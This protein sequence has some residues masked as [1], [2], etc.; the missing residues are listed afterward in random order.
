ML[1]SKKVFVDTCVVIEFLKE[2]LELNKSNCYIS[3]I[4]LMEL[5][6]GAKNKQDLREIK[7]KLQGFKLLETNQEVIDLSTQIIEHF[8]LSHN[9]KI[10]DAII[11]STC[12]IH[13]LP[14]ATYNIKDFKYIPNLE[15]VGN[16][17][18]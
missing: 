15:I 1:G 16:F 3:H 13:K 18:H 9:A 8:S 6:I 4:V 2:N 14:I 12:L 11:A 10:Q 5:Y 17:L 7:V